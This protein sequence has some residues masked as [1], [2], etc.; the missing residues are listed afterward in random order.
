[1][2]NIK[3]IHTTVGL[4]E[5]HFHNTEAASESFYSIGA[6][7]HRT[8]VQCKRHSCNGVVEREMGQT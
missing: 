6:S 2:I 1:M 8:R 3:E 5:F 7:A 4:V